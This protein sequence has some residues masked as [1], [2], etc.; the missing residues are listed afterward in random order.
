MNPFF[1]AT[2][3]ANKAHRHMKNIHVIC[4]RRYERQPSNFE[5]LKYPDI[6]GLLVLRIIYFFYVA[7]T[8]FENVCG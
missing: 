4:F 3:A 2:V 6:E 7:L 5:K 1:T 8:I